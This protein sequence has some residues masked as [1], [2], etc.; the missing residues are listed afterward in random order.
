MSRQKQV[1]NALRPLPAVI[2][3]YSAAAVD[4]QLFDLLCLQRVIY[5]LADR[6]T[7]VRARF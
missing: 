2:S 7:S 6:G 5:P 1:V 4:W 3:S